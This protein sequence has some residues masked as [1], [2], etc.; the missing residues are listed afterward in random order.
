MQLKTGTRSADVDFSAMDV[1]KGKFVA[2][3]GQALDF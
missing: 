3:D 1:G 2:G